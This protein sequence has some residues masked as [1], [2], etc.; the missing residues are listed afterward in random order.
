MKKSLAWVLALVMLLSLLTGCA[1]NDGGNTSDNQIPTDQT[2]Q[3]NP[4]V[5]PVP[6]TPTVDTMILKEADDDQHLHPLGG[7]P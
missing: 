1:K 7:K 2:E 4:P 5:E 3:N 6:E